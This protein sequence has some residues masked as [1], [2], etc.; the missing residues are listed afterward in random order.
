MDAFMDLVVVDPNPP[1]ASGATR[2]VGRINLVLT[3]EEC[4]DFATKFYKV[5]EDGSISQDAR[6]RLFERQITVNLTNAGNALP[7]L[8]TEST[9]TS[10]WKSFFGRREVASVPAST[11][12]AAAGG[13]VDSN[14]SQ[15]SF[16]PKVRSGSRKLR[17]DMPFVLSGRPQTSEILISTEA[18]TSLDGRWIV[19][20]RVADRESEN[21]VKRIKRYSAN[22]QNKV[23]IASSGVEGTEA[24]AV[25]GKPEVSP[26]A[27]NTVSS[28]QVAAA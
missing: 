24:S 20:G 16:F 26:V 23:F 21:I 18:A 13:T 7:G 11:E 10:G 8:T 14:S 9:N 22:T 3:P 28:G 12:N 5:C 25:P 27:G 6:F 19:F 4:Q 1:P 2:K 15:S 17:H